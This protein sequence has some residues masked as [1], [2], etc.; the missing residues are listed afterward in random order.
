VPEQDGEVTCSSPQKS[1]VVPQKPYLEQQTFKGQLSAADHS[2]PH[3][4][5]QFDLRSQSEVQFPAP[6]NVGPNPHTPPVPQQ[7]IA[8]GESGELLFQSV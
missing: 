4:G 2:E 6:Q 1:E 5:S 8:H 7:P 3:P